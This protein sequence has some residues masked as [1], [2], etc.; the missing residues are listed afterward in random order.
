M[1]NI[2]NLNRDYLIKINVKEATIDVPKMTFWNTDKKTSNMFV[3]LV[4][5]MS[6]N[7]LISQYVT[8]QNATDYKI[9]LN[10]IKPKTKQY[11]T[12]EATLLNEEKALFEIDLPDEFTDQV[13]DYSFEFE[14]SSKVDSNDESITTSNGTYKVNGSI[15]TNLNEEISSSPD[16]PILKQLIEQVKSLQGGDLTGYQKKNDAAQKTIV[17]DGKLYLT[18]LDGTKLD[19]GTTLPTGSGTSIDDTNTT[20]DKTWS[21][22]KIDSQFKDIANLSLTK[23]S[24]GKVYIKKQDGTL[25]GD[26]IEIGGSDVDLSKITMSMSGQTLKL[27]NDGTQITTVEIP[28][29]VV[30]DEQLTSIIQSKIDDGTISSISLGTNSVGTLNLQDKA[31]TPGKTDFFN[32]KDVN[33]FDKTK[34]TQ[35]Y[36]LYNNS[37]YSGNTY[38]MTSD[39]IPVVSG[40]T[41]YW[42]S[43]FTTNYTNSGTNKLYAQFYDVNKAVVANTQNKSYTA[44]V[45]G[46][47]R[48]TF[49]TEQ[50]DCMI[51]VDSLKDY[52]PYESK[53]IEFADKY[54]DD[55]VSSIMSNENVI[56]E[57]LPK[58]KSSNL[59]YND[60]IEK[61]KNTNKYDGV[62]ESRHTNFITT[63]VINGIVSPRY[64]KRDTS[65]AIG[66]L[67]TG[68][69]PCKKGDTFYLSSKVAKL[70]EYTYEEKD[71]NYTVNDNFISYDYADKV[72]VYTI[73]GDN[74]AFVEFIFDA[75]SSSGTTYLNNDGSYKSGTTLSERF[76]DG[77][78]YALKN[79]NLGKYISPNIKD[80]DINSDYKE[81]FI[82]NVIGD[83]RTGNV[84]TPVI[85][86][87]LQNMKLRPLYGKKIVWIG[88]SL[89]N[90]GAGDGTIGGTGFL[91]IIAT[92]EGAQVYNQGRAGASWE[93]GLGTWND[94]HTTYTPTD[95]EKID[96]TAIARVNTLVTNKA[97]FVP[98]Y[99]IFM[100]G[101]NRRSDGETT[102][103][104]TNLHTMCGAIKHCLLQV[105]NNFPNCV[106]G[107]VLPPQRHE[108]MSGQESANEKIKTICNYYSVPTFDAFHEGGLLNHERNPL[109]ST[110]GSGGFSDGLHLS[111]LG[112]SIL[113]R[114]F[115]HWLKTL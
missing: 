9:T 14:V 52:V 20:T 28:T 54:I 63:D 102:D 24:D 43:V 68:L 29:A 105:Y 17:E 2:T 73:V 113:G 61:I 98:D 64:L 40:K 101:T 85:N 87:L 99:I 95:E 53:E 70:K 80:M 103:E 11:K 84:L 4:I 77:T 45:D 91:D 5:N 66:C 65:T 35:S 33:L 7:E 97:T 6:T 56:T 8:V 74:T 96:Y 12:I 94:T 112:K 48:V 10:V 41:Y 25:I 50:N 55:I 89:T 26:G 15:L 59:I 46:Y 60:T 21:S 88:D 106:I 108:G 58:I 22:S 82:K 109:V 90:W 31:I 37:G 110:A 62:I 92:N 16:L 1:S 111:D 23:H 36:R 3:Q 27:M 49:S 75:V 72:N 42:N 71:T 104:Y 44:T 69:I 51:S 79:V 78:T 107:V 67:G 32:C 57:I 115:S 86:T 30:T 39:Y 47:M 19:D 76:N 114:K 81:Y 34:V 18:K 93:Y 83:E 38:S 13:G 100:M